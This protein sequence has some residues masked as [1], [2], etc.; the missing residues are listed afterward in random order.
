MISAA[1]TYNG[2]PFTLAGELGPLARLQ[3]PARRR[4]WP[5]QL[6]L[7]AAGAKLDV[8]GSVRAADAGPRLHG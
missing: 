6:S 8:D 7:E 2:A 1:A 4:A 5:V 3:E